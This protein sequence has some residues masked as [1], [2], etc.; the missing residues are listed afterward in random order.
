MK[1]QLTTILPMVVAAAA[2]AP[3]DVLP[4]SSDPAAPPDLRAPAPIGAQEGDIVVA[5]GP[6]EA[7]PGFADDAPTSG[8]GGG[9]P[10]EPEPSTGAGA[11]SDPAL[12][13]LDSDCPASPEPCF[14]S[15]CDAGVCTKTPRPVGTL[16][17]SA[18]QFAGDCA[19][20]RCDAYGLPSNVVDPTDADDHNDCTVDHCV[21]GLA[22]H[23]PVSA[24]SA[25]EQ[26]HCGDTG[27]CYHPGAFVWKASKELGGASVTVDCVALDGDDAAVVSGRLDPSA[28]PY[29]RAFVAKV[30]RH[31]GFQWVR[32]L[33]SLVDGG[34]RVAVAPSGR[35]V[36]SFRHAFA[37]AGGVGATLDALGPDGSLLWERSTDAGHHVLP[38]GL[39]LDAT[40]VVHAARSF[41]NGSC[42][43]FGGGAICDDGVARYDLDGGFLGFDVGD[44]LPIAC[45]PSAVTSWGA[46]VTAT[47]SGSTLVLEKIA[48]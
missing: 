16:L 15:T 31:G 42:F 4:V 33:G 6:R 38:G 41:A 47:T 19:A 45:A 9:G 43:D 3:G 26:G 14:R 36:V 27:V 11:G 22:G 30:S 39:A 12:C 48:P 1:T 20:L 24:G 40:G 34:V 7:F 23:E 8:A 44:S 28:L 25:C 2:C 46:V 18:Y 29:S 21:D 37:G 32:E 10:V 13:Q 17:P 35:A 5:H